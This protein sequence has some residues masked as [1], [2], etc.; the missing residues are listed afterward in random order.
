M[1]AERLTAILMLCLSLKMA[2]TL[3][4]VLIV[5][6]SVAHGYPAAFQDLQGG[7]GE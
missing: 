5:A 7:V 4:S 2:L 6:V 1:L 3:A